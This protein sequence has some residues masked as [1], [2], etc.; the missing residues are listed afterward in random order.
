[1][2]SIEFYIPGKPIAKKRPRFARRG[3]FVSTYNPQETEEGNFRWLAAQKLR[4]FGLNAPIPAGVPI[5]LICTFLMPIP[6]SKP[7][8]FKE[9]PPPHTSTPDVDN[10]LKFLKDCFNNL[11]WCD[12]SQVIQVEASKKYS[13]EPGTEINLKW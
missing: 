11:A 4:E 8:K 5:I 13:T 9:N 1:M 10:L 2:N 6:V 12:D 3:K 7:K